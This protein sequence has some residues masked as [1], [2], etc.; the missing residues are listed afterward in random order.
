MTS[1]T[2]PRSP[3]GA[4]W[5]AALTSALLGAAIL[6]DALPGMNWVIWVASAAAALIVART[7]SGLPLDRPVLILL[8]WAILL[9]S[10]AAFTTNEFKHVL[11]F[12][13]VGMLLGLA[14][15]VIGTPNWSA[16]S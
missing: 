12:L 11:I 15:I 7:L 6:F 8:A 13:S 14:V 1:I 16:L 10:G 3:I 4:V 9:A 2:A 5:I